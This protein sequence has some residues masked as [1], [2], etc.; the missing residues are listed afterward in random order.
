MT[1]PS[2][3]GRRHRAIAR[4]RMLAGR[5]PDDC[6]RRAAAR[7]CLALRGTAAWRSPAGGTA[8]RGGTA[9][10]ERRAGRCGF[11]R[12][13]GVGGFRRRGMEAVFGA[14]QC[15]DAGGEEAIAT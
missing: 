14:H 8:V 6:V 11:D 9:A 3:S 7:P 13:L 10:E 15:A 2:T 1:A 12:V 4:A 5:R